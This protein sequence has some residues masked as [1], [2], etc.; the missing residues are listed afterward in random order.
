MLT[1][2]RGRQPV[3]RGSEYANSETKLLPNSPLIVVSKR[4][5][6]IE[7]ARFFEDSSSVSFILSRIEI[8]KHG[9]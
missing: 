3:R 9:T 8:N 6:Q 1:K 4:N 5:G 7:S 2:L